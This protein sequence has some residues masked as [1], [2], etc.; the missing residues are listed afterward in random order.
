MFNID[1][2]VFVDELAHAV[3]TDS[4]SRKANIK[5]VDYNKLEADISDLKA[6]G[7]Q[8]LHR[9][10]SL[11]TQGKAS[12]DATLQREHRDVWLKE[13]GK[14]DTSC[15]SIQYELD[16]LCG[17]ALADCDKDVDSETFATN[18]AFW[19]DVI[20]MEGLLTAEREKFW[21][22]KMTPLLSIRN[23]IKGCL[24][25]HTKD[26]TQS[27]LSKM[28]LLHKALLKTKEEHLL[29]ST[30]LEEEVKELQEEINLAKEKVSF[31]NSSVKTTVNMLTSVPIELANLVSSDKVLEKRVMLQFTN[32]NDHFLTL[33]RKL[34]E[35][36][37]ELLRCD[38]FGGWD[39]EENAT[40]HLIMEQYATYQP[41]KRALYMD[42]LRKQFLRKSR[43]EIVS[44]EKWYFSKLH[45]QNRKNAYLRSWTMNREELILRSQVLSE[46]AL[47]SKELKQLKEETIEKQK[48]LCHQLHQKV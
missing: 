11:V 27:C 6:H 10:T 42:R 21:E 2:I 1:F 31:S 37:Q 35:D 47:K 45:Y 25:S 15:R 36:H 9:V 4:Q 26:K 24:L 38:K 13:K 23:S 32:L 34:D 7:S 40:F 14:M 39:E 46:E 3:V 16:F 22:D 20:K 17:N 19:K 33:L 29:V 43:A 41:M 48:E 12:K 28:S 30:Q 18:S 8:Q 44:H 5:K